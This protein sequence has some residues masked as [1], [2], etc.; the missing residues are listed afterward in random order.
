M[1]GKQC[2]EFCVSLLLILL[3]FSF[4]GCANKS[5]P[6]STSFSIKGEVTEESTD[7][8]ELSLNVP[9]LSGFDAAETINKEINNSVAA[10]I[11]E[12]EDAASLMVKDG[13]RLKAGLEVNYL[14]SKSGDIVSLWV[15]MENYLGGAHG[16]YWVEPYT[17][18]YYTNEIYH[19]RDL[20]L[21]G[22]VSAELVE[23]KIIYKIQENPDLYFE[24]AVET[25][26]HYENDLP[27]YING[28]KVIVYFPLYDI[29]P[30][31]G[32]IQFFDF[33]AEELKVLLR[34]EIYESIK[35]G[36][37]VDTKGTILEH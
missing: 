19:F 36:E 32:G 3:L 10:A 12:V 17:F 23:E 16:L 18:N 13:S 27:F 4:I 34:P 22:D 26:K 15:M 8:K 6:V 2:K 30:Y 29:A 25:V 20:F 9:V 24:S 31:A 7:F 37:P 11:A 33:D 35:T 1:R 5:K 14:Y 28:N 21:E